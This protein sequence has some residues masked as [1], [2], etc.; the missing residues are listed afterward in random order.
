MVDEN[1]RA[2]Y[3]MRAQQ[4]RELA[5]SAN[6]PSLR[7]IHEKMASKFLKLAKTRSYDDTP[8]RSP[9]SV[10]IGSSQ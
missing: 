3:R 2:Y 7:M 6:E 1:G 5:R 8:A 4:S 10:T 9:G